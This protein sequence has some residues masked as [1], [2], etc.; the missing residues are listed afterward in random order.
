M[1]RLPV[2]RHEEVG[3]DQAGNLAALIAYYG[4]LFLFPLMLVVVTFAASAAAEHIAGIAISVVL[5]LVLSLLAFR[6]LTAADVTWSDVFPGVVVAA[7]PGPCYRPSA[8][9]S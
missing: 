9:T 8:G 7:P 6:I 5:N 3:D 2:R 1:D 4:F